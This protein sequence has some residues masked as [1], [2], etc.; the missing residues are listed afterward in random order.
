VQFAQGFAWRKSTELMQI[1]H[2][3]ALQEAYNC[4][5]K[6]MSCNR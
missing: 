4:A 2:S 3:I 1:V 5:V 6:W